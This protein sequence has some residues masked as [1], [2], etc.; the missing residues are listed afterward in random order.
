M[1]LRKQG[2]QSQLDRLG[3]PFHDRLNRLLQPEELAFQIDGAG[4]D[5]PFKTGSSDC[6]AA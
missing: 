3:F 2:D 1:A 4:H 6:R 5:Q